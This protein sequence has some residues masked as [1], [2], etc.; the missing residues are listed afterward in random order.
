MRP[1]HLSRRSR[2]RQRQRR[3]GGS[4]VP[5]GGIYCAP[6]HPSPAC[7]T[8]DTRHL[9]S[10]IESKDPRGDR[11]ARI[12]QLERLPV[13]ITPCPIQEAVIEVRF[14]P[15]APAEAV[16]GL[17]YA[18]LRDSYPDSEDLPLAQIPESIRRQDPELEH[19]PVRRLVRPGFMVQVGPKV[20]SVVTRG[21]YP[22]WTALS[23]ESRRVLD[24]V[25]QQRVVDNVQRLGLRYVNFFGFNIFPRLKLTLSIAETSVTEHDTYF[26]A[27]VPDEGVKRLLQVANSAKL[28]GD[29]THLRGSVVD[30][31]AATTESLDRFLE[32]PMPLLDQLHNSEK[33]LFFT[34]L[35]PEFLA[36]LNPEY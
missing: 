23:S 35:E 36:S 26:R 33:Q 29:G 28:E 4:Q 15:S 31:D 10:R 21:E 9:G 19:Q 3:A 1:R 20:V 25:R 12:A 30:I 2:P 17:L 32:D 6:G 24:L 7:K 34:L 5:L 16:Y 22:G 14:S 18:A 13:K 11:L 8:L 27:A